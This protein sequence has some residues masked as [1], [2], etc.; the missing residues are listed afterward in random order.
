[1]YFHKQFISGFLNILVYL[2]INITKQKPWYYQ[3]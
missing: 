3:L 2:V 1:M